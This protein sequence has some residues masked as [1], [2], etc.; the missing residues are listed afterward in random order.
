M[1]EDEYTADL[2]KIAGFKFNGVGAI[3]YLRLRDK[4]GS[5]IFEEDFEPVL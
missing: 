2:G 5:L 4:T 3:D 1:L